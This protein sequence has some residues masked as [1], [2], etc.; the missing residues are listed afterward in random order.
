MV[1]G[2]REDEEL[3]LQSRAGT[4]SYLQDI[5]EWEAGGEWKQDCEPQAWRESGQ[6]KVWADEVPPPR[7]R[8]HVVLELPVGQEES[9]ES[10]KMAINMQLKKPAFMLGTARLHQP[11]ATEMSHVIRL[12]RE[13]S[14]FKKTSLVSISS[15]LNVDWKWHKLWVTSPLRFLGEKKQWKFLFG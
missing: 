1:S 8:S 11:W 10:M 6:R 13:A 2:K 12:G 5:R 3:R 9:S 14:S 4:R 7:L 15:V